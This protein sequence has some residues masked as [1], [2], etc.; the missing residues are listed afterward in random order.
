MKKW[1][2]VLFLLL[3]FPPA[4]RGEAEIVPQ[5]AAYALGE[6]VRL[7]VAGG[8]T[9]KGCKYSVFLD[10]NELFRQ[11]SS[12][13]HTDVWYL[14]RK[15][16]A[17][18]IDVS[19]T[20][21]D[22]KK[23][24]ASCEFLVT[25]VPAAVPEGALYSQKDGSWADDKYGKEHLEKAGCA[26]FTLSNALHFL[27]RTG[28]ETE[29]AAL[30]SRYG[31]CLIEGGTSNVRLI[32]Q[33]AKDFDFVTESALV[34]TEAGIRD[35]MRDG[36][37]FTF[38]IVKGHI[39]FACGLSE[40]G[41][42]IRI[43]DSAPS[44][45]MDRIKSG[46]L[47]QRNEAGDFIR[48]KDLSEFPDARYYFET[49]QYGGL[50]YWMDL[51]YVAK[52]GVRIIRP[53]WLRVKTESGEQNAE[54]VT[55]GTIESVVRADGEEMTV[56]TGS[57]IWR[58]EEEAPAAA[59]VVS[60]KA[61]LLLDSGGAQIGRV[62]R[63]ALLPLIAR[64]ENRLCVRFEGRLGY[65]GPED[66]QAVPIPPENARAGTVHINGTVSGKSNVGFRR[67]PLSNSTQIGYWP[68]GTKV[69]VLEERDGFY[70][71]EANGMRGWLLPKN[72]MLD[73]EK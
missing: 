68:T 71:A 48:V 65:L 49:G 12:D 1:L 58:S 34:R 29:P 35:L 21:Q 16:G 10:G 18:R 45:T 4:A 9:V 43:V 66:A 11:K 3:L 57:L 13:S 40:D 25:E 54:L 52:R 7:T 59:C 14:P 39:A 64:E 61:A 53:G 8:R 72:V 55:F 51:S 26:I 19:V 23:E 73:E 62:P 15:P 31:Y 27:G 38:S 41:S 6:A 33:A 20:C 17:Y 2:A 32:R 37:V 28:E 24:N 47:Y 50:T 30:A 70:L 69:W 5:R 22:K 56:P 60:K 67:S 44:A 46:S 42:K 36:A 63:G